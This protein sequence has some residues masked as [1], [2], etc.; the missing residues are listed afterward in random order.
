MTKLRLSYKLYSGFGGILVVLA[1]VAAIGYFG[2]GRACTAVTDLAEIHVPLLQSLATIDSGVHAQE[3]AVTQYAVQA[4]EKYLDHYREMDKE[5]DRALTRAAKLIASDPDLVEAGWSAKMDR[6]AEK[7]DR[8][9]VAAATRLLEAA[10]ADRSYQAWAPLSAA[11]TRASEDVMTEIDALLETNNKEAAAVAAQASEAGRTA[12]NLMPIIGSIALVAGALLAF[13]LTRGVTGPLNRIIADLSNGSG[14]IGQ[15]SSQVAAAAQDLAEGGSEQAAA[16]EQASSSLEE[17]AAMTKSNADNSSQADRL[18][19]ESSR[20]VDQAGRDM[21]EMTRSME[22]IAKSGGEI[23]KIVKSIDEIAFQTNLLALNAAVEA[24]RA[25]EAGAGFAV[26]ADEVRALALRAAEAAKTTQELID[27][28]ISR[29]E[30]GS[31]LAAK[32]RAGFDGII[33]SSQRVAGLIAETARASAEQAQ[34]VDQINTTIGQME[35][36]VQ[37]NAANAEES[38]SAAEE[39]DAQ[40]R[41]LN[42]MVAQLVALVKGGAGRSR[43]GPKRPPTKMITHERPPV[44]MIARRPSPGEILPLDADD[45]SDF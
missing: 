32:S 39:L 3:L 17:M 24:A 29:I 16:L 36:V 1:L 13:F 27:G 30:Q 2:I 31:T 19:R 10:K 5:V 26:V 21:D 14:Q 37:Q 22:E 43:P 38:A 18:M 4:D 11:L 15:A 45:L 7:H 44:K 41:T 23:S 20:V 9:F 42:S 12:R 40:T 33:G 25:G 6:I 34:G 8:V 28:T 35:R